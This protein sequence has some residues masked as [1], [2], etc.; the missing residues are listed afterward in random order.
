MKD[1]KRRISRFDDRKV[2]FTDFFDTLVHR[3][4]HPNYA[5]RLWAKFMVRELAIP[6][7][8][9]QLFTIR[10]E[11]LAY[12]GKKQGRST[13][14][15]KYKDV[16]TEV[17]H[18]LVNTE[19]LHDVPFPR[20][21]KLFER[22]DFTAEIS[23]QFK[24]ETLI[25][26]L[27]HF[28][29]KGYRIYLMSDFY[30][31]K[32]VIEKIL[33]FHKIDHLFNAVFLSSSVGHS[34]EKG[35]LYP[36]VLDKLSLD[37]KE[38]LMIGDNMGSDVTNAHKHGIPSLHLKHFSHKFRNKKNLLGSDKNDFKKVCQTIESR[39]KKSGHPFSEYVLHFYF[40]TERLYIN[41]KK[42]KVNDLFFLAREGHFLKQL[43]D[44]YQ[45]MNLFK[46]EAK[47]RTHY[48]KASRQSATQLALRPL[49]EED[50]GGLLK[51]FGK[52][53]LDHFLDWFPFSDET[54]NDIKQEI[55]KTTDSNHAAFFQS[56]T[57]QY[58]RSS[59][60]FQEA[61][62]QNRY[63]QKMAFL[64]Y[65]KSFGADF[66][67]DGLAL[68]DVGWGG[69]MQES[70]YKFLKRKIP[71]TG[72]YLGLK[73]IYNIEKGTKRYG[74]NFSIYPSQD[75]S[76][77]VLMANGQLYEQ[78][79]AA[80]HGSTLSYTMGENGQS[81]TVEFHEPNEKMV[82][83]QY[84]SPIQEY[85]FSEFKN[86]FNDLRAIDYSQAMVQNYIT[87]MAL[88]TGIFTN[89]K[90]L[91]FV[92]QITKG[93]YQNV[94]ENKVGLEYNPNQV[95]TSKVALIKTFLKSPEKVFRYLVK[96]KP[97]MYAKGYYWMSWPLNL[98]YYYIKFNF[99]A[100]RKWLNKG[101]LS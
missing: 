27:E 72:Y 6:M 34:K 59:P 53:S 101:L 39:C 74:L 14:E 56:E 77:D 76:D 3:T 99:W 54:K 55:P 44:C 86:L 73:E 43:F 13:L 96:I 100:K 36:Y 90:K 11:A 65:L 17:Y 7:E 38:V 15:I 62:D 91:K 48:L 52:M 71:V 95:K 23:V 87:D 42:N 57:M 16:I 67:K 49:P 9:E 85:M 94:G 46:S 45:D 66:D 63:D 68:V 35:S 61:Y 78:L 84:V 40:F 22:A 75:F 51:R 92:N 21:K 26:T 70:I 88:R 1:L 32:K 2:L 83:D 12:L 82:F 28:K 37:A 98:T 41:A 60:R 18:R 97:F 33:D 64:N 30:L 69:T 50:F 5:I 80:P 79:L 29:Q 47:I 31:S 24:N 8:G 81:P 89:R 20:F 25:S 58:L 93:F 4:V 10:T 19:N